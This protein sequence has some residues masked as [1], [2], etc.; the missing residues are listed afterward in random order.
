MTSQQTFLETE[1]IYLA[2]QGSQDAFSE[3]YQRHL[4]AVHQYIQRRVG[5]YTDAE[6]LTQTVFVKAWQALAEYRPGKSPF[7]A[8]LYR[9]AH[10]TVIDHYRARRQFVGWEELATTAATDYPLE[11]VLL[12]AEEET[13]IHAA[14]EQLRPSYRA[15][16]VRRFLQELDYPETA[17]ELGRQ[18]NGVRVIQHRALDALRVLLSQ[19]GAL[20]IAVAAMMVALALSAPIVQAAEQALPGE[21]L[22]PVRTAVEA[23]RLY[24]ANETDDIRLHNEFATRRIQDL[25]SL[26]AH[27]QT[28]AMA[29]TTAAL[30]NEIEQATSKVLSSSK[31]APATV[32]A[33]FEVTL[34]EQAA[35]L[36]VLAKTSAP[37]Q[38][39][40]IQSVRNAISAAQTQIH[41]PRLSEPRKDGDNGTHNQSIP[42]VETPTSVPDLPAT[43]ASSVSTIL[44]S[45]P[46]STLPQSN[47]PHANPMDNQIDLE[48]RF[49]LLTPSPSAATS[50]QTNEQPAA[51][52][53]P[54]P[55]KRI[56][57]ANSDA[58]PIVA[59]LE[60]AIDPNPRNG[61]EEQ[62]ASSNGQQQEQPPLQST[63][64]APEIASSREEHVPIS[65]PNELVNLPD[66]TGDDTEHQQAT[67]TSSNNQRGNQ[68]PD[69]AT[70]QPRQQPSSPADQAEEHN[71]DRSR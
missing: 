54:A 71:V 50:T 32:V 5:E 15:V 30:I 3:L 38:Q 48:D 61:V 9:I 29:T 45:R 13:I 53:A 41:P 43:P 58:Q 66:N 23:A 1:I 60:T 49:D 70:E 42:P 33:Q 6:D 17:A 40:A 14:I 21:R 28:E 7:R 36:D 10:N 2:Q 11:E 65:Q 16:I 24:L 55:D 22:Y 20:R 39:A 62:R 44:H 57:Q 34:T 25:R 68:Q 47:S 37:S 52:Q 4:Q 18:V 67:A 63:V 46:I 27:K 12:V 64:A 35:A 8:W 26:S 19:Q 59:S 56:N 51:V 69:Q 31:G